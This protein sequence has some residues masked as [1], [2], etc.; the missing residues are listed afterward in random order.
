MRSL[1]IDLNNFSRYPTL[2]VGYLVATLRNH[3]VIVDVLSPFSRGIAAYP[4]LTK[5][6]K[7]ELYFN[8]LKY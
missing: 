1:I 2:S 8:Y 5:A 4:R 7:R 6:R 3:N